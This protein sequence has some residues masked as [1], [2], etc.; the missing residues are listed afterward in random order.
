MHD[1]HSSGQFLRRIQGDT[2]GSA[3]DF[4]QEFLQNAVLGLKG[5]SRRR[6][7]EVMG[8]S[9]ALAGL[10]SCMKQPDEKIVPYVKSP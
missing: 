3:D 2:G 7:L 10:S 1:S 5:V 6:F 8:A 9:L 4:D